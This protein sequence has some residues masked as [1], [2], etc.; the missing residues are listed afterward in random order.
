MRKRLAAAPLAV[1]QFV[2]Y[3]CIG[4][5]GASL[6][7]ALFAVLDRI[8]W[9][10]VLATA[11]SVS[12]GIVT[13]FVLN[14]SLNFRTRHRRVARFLAFY[15]VGAFGILLSVVTVFLLTS[16]ADADPLI[17][18]LI[19]IPVVVV[20]QFGLNKYVTFAR[21]PEPVRPSR[22]VVGTEG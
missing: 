7:F 6:D 1:R 19:S 16:L 17:A 15:A 2:L 22:D 11:V 13:N 14:V 20:A 10:P 3:C 8:G 21:L 5:V 4:I 18:K 12:L 9:N